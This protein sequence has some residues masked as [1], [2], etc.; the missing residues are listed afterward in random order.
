M[1]PRERW[2]LRREDGR[3][4]PRLRGRNRVD[5]PT[6]AFFHQIESITP[7]TRSVVSSW[8]SFNFVEIRQNMHIATVK[9]YLGTVCMR[10]PQ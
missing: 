5:A 1:T 2:A 4:R 9:A 8:I 7:S 3:G 6:S 10:N